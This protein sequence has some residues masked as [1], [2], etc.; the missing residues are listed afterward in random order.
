MAVPLVL[1]ACEE[2]ESEVMIMIAAE[3]E[4]PAQ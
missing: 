2:S 3:L 1:T 4:G